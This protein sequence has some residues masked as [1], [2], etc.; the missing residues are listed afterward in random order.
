M[1][2]D[3]AAFRSA[4]P[5]FAS[6]TDYPDATLNNK[7]SVAKCYIE[8]NSCT[9]DDHCRQYVYQLMVAHLL[10][11]DIAVAS[12]QPGRLISSAA[13]GPVNVSFAEPPNKSNFTFWLQTTPYGV[14]LSALLSINAIGD[15]YGGSLTLQSFRSF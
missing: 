4:F 14:Q 12:G 6:V 2:L 9:F 5:Q 13:E 11:I 8:D 3:I 1:D 7:M 10:S 15:Y